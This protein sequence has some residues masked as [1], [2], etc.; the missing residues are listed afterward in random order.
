LDEDNFQ[1]NSWSGDPMRIYLALLA[2]TA[3]TACGGGGPTTVGGNA[4]IG[5]GAGG[6]NSGGNSSNATN[7]FVTPTVARTYAGVGGS[8]VFS[9]MTETA[10]LVDQQAQVYAGNASTVRDSK[11][12][13]TYDPRDAIFTLIVKDPKSGASATTRF[14]DPASRT[15]FTGAVEPQWGTPNLPDTSIRYLQAGDGDPLSPYRASGAG[16]VNAGTNTIAPDGLSPSE[17]QSTSLFYEVPGSTTKYVS[18]AGYV[19]NSI[20]WNDVAIAGVLSHQANWHLERGAFAY[21]IQTDNNAVPQTGSGTYSGKML[22]T[23]VNNPTLDGAFGPVL[24]TY[25]QWIS[26]TSVTEVNFANNS[27]AVSLN[28]IVSAPQIDRFSGPTAASVTTGTSFTAAGTGTINLVNTG[29]FT[30]QFQSASVGQTNNGAPTAVTIAGSSLDG[31]FYGP[32]AQEV[33][34]GFRIVGGTPDQR[35]DIVGAFT[36]AKQ[37]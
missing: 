28:G 16:R 13:L 36:G 9:Y 33:G 35:I 21:G 20:S 7:I 30:G 11:I 22:A 6:S 32:V 34:G 29:G 37:P 12:S 10:N 24:P 17:Y 14:Q 26:G 25:F 5:A 27:V 8:Q 3:L 1:S 15:N 31:A 2:A 4:V 18:F 23:M 19:R